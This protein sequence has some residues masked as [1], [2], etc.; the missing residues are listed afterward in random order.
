MIKTCP[1]N[2]RP[3]DQ[4][5]ARPSQW[6]AW[7]DE[8]MEQNE[9]LQALRNAIMELGGNA[10]LVRATRSFRF[11]CFRAVTSTLKLLERPCSNSQYPYDCSKTALPL[12][13]QCR[14]LR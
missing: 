2:Y 13:A 14:P 1:T 3:T 10:D 5:Q 7:A 11:L 6:L 12:V 9:E 8:V 4:L